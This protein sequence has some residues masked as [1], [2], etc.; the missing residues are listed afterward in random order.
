MHFHILNVRKDIPGFLPMEEVFLAEVL[1]A[2]GVRDIR[3]HSVLP[4][5][6]EA[7]AD[8]IAGMSAEKVKV[9]FWE[10]AS[11]KSCQT[12]LD[13][14]RLA[15]EIRRRS[16][17][18]L[19]AVGYWAATLAPHY[20]ERFQ[21]FDAVIAGFN[22][23]KAA[24][25]L[26]A[27]ETG[28]APGEILDATGPCDWNAYDLN[29]SWLDTPEK[30][31]GNGFVS[32][33]RTTFGCPKNCHFCYNNMLRDRDARYSE[34]DLDTVRIDV[35]HIMEKYGDTPLQLKD[36]NFFCNK[37]RA[38]QIM[39]MLRSMGVQITSNLDVTVRDAEESIFR[40]CAEAGV[41]SMFFGLESF[42]EDSLE[43]FNKRYPV[44]K[45]EQLFELGDAWGITL[46]GC[47]LLGLPW[48]T[49]ESI[50][51]DIHRAFE[52][53]ERHKMLRINLNNY[54]PLLETE[55]QRQYFP[56][57]AEKLSLEELND[58]YNFRMTPE[59]Q[60]RL[61]G[62]VFENI[63]F[64]K[65]RVHA[66]A[67]NSISLLEHYHVP[68]ALHPLFAPVRALLC[69]NVMRSGEDNA[70]NRFLTT[71]RIVETRRS[72]TRISL[73]IKKIMGEVR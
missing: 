25:A 46:T 57:V 67:L 69:D 12:L 21:P 48:Q 11:Y 27:G 26:A 13:Y 65:L 47:L 24:Q 28:S 35:E 63:N 62:P 9:V 52:S 34:R 6:V 60:K 17:V 43:R 33:Y 41:N 36:R 56:D 45:L 42:H 39:D 7:C 59:L 58:I 37:E 20:P 66:L 22:F 71:E 49:S 54:H 29:L 3:V 8:E 30:Y 4:N 14:F 44:S 18:Y 61:Y 38:F 31:L 53:M 1:A 72:L 68:E 15:E 50:E 2:S 70:I 10:S 51:A 64:E 23:E 55:L 16:G 73:E 32:G 19:A 5:E 40:K